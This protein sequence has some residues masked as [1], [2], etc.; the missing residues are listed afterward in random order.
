MATWLPASSSHKPPDDDH[1]THNLAKDMFNGLLKAPSRPHTPLSAK[2]RLLN[3]A[4]SH[5]GHAP[6]PEPA[7]EED[8]QVLKFRTLYEE[9]ESKI[10][11][12]FDTQGAMSGPSSVIT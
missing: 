5:S 11:S 6:D 4:S 12:L 2:L 10:A 1:H 9:T 3:G 7:T 8:P